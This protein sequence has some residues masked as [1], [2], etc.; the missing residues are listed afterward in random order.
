[1]VS[2]MVLTRVTPNTHKG[3]GACTPAGGASIV[4]STV[5]WSARN[6]NAAGR[7]DTTSAMLF[8]RRPQEI[9]PAS[10]RSSAP[11][12]ALRDAEVEVLLSTNVALRRA[13]RV[14]P[15]FSHD[16]AKR[17]AETSLWHGRRNPASHPAPVS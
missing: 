6:E 9:A 5:A 8:S 4:V 11:R 17:I 16:D 12:D 10:L 15:P 2:G 1:M 7:G 13:N 14:R 3:A